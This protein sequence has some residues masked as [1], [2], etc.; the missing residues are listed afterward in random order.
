MIAIQRESV[1]QAIRSRRQQF[2]ARAR[3]CCPIKLFMV[4][5]Q[6]IHAVQNVRK[7]SSLFSE[8]M[9]ILSASL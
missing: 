5:S 9:S 8:L 7:Y 2:H 3:A 4:R 1:V 6:S